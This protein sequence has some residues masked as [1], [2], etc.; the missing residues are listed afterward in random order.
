MLSL[1]HWSGGAYSLEEIE[2]MAAVFFGAG[3]DTAAVHL[4]AFV[5]YMVKNPEV[6]AKLM[7]GLETAVEK[8]ELT[9]RRPT[10]RPSSC[11]FSG[12]A[13]TRSSIFILLF[14]C[15]FLGLFRRKGRS[16]PVTFSQGVS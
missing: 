13:W 12:L 10:P 11:L 16:S 2:G 9:S 7:E 5:Y 14:L 1:K 8:G 6:Q 3:T 4:R 15:R